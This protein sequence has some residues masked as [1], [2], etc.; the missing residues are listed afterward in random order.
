[1]AEKEI[2]EYNEQTSVNA[3]DK[4]LMQD[5]V[6][7]ETKYALASNFAA[8][9][10][11]VDPSKWTNLY[12]FYGYKTSATNIPADVATKVQFDSE[13]YDM[14][15]NFD[16][17]AGFSRF[18]APFDGVYV[19]YGRVEYATTIVNGDN[20]YVSVLVNGAERL[21]GNQLGAAFGTSCGMIVAGP[22]LMSALEYAELYAFQ[23]SDNTEATQTNSGQVYFAGQLLTRV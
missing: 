17:T 23:S 4:F 21:R 2:R 8:L 15:S 19:F 20:S 11:T 9:A 10:G 18:T 14:D 5:G 3:S 22:I 7:N 12:G 6:S 13:I 16:T 1:M